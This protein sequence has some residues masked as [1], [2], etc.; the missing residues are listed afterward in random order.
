MP[1][2]TRTLSS[3]PED[4]LRTRIAKLIGTNHLT[5]IGLPFQF[6]QVTEVDT[7]DRIK[8]RV[9]L[10]DDEL[11]DEEL[12]WCLPMNNRQTGSPEVNSAAIIGIWDPKHPYV[13]FWFTAVTDD[14]LSDLLSS[15]S[16]KEELDDPEK[17]WSN[18]QKLTEM[19]FGHFPDGKK[20][21]YIKSKS[22]KINYKLGIRGKSKN[23][24]FFE[25]SKTTLVQNLAQGDESKLVLSDKA[26]L[27]AKNLDLLSTNSI[28]TE[29]PV[30]A[31]PLFLFMSQQLA[32]LQT[33][34]QVL[35]SVP[36][37][38]LG[39]PC[40]KSPASDPLEGMMSSLQTSFSQLKITGK[41]K[42]IKI[43]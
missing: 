27:L 28:N 6:G 16:L 22:K 37:L 41:S 26:E 20:R 33:I 34:V 4:K 2:L 30:F 18:I 42:Y 31:D 39:I 13:R 11:D 15:S 14:S 12:P 21:A 19:V 10:L 38:F 40:V 35:T 25:E 29:R 7:R 24:L 1:D 32:L 43:N 8:V 36:A 17:I 5:S 23:T 9:P 3:N